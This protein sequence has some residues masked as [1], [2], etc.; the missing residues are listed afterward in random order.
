MPIDLASDALLADLSRLAQEE[1]VSAAL[2]GGAVR[3]MLL[4]REP[5][6][7]DLVI[8]GPPMPFARR[9]ARELK[10]AAVELD[11]DWGIARVV[12]SGSGKVIDL[13]KLQGDRLEDDLMRRDLAL[14]AMAVRLDGS[15]TLLDPAGGQEDIARR[16]IRAISLDNL[17][18]DPVRPLRVLRFAATLDFAIDYETLAWVEIS[19]RKLL[20]A[21][22]ERTIY[23]L[24]RILALPQVSPWVDRLYGLGIWSLLVPEF[25]ALSQIPPSLEHHL[26]GLAHSLE[27]VRQL[28]HLLSTLP[29]WAGPHAAQ[30]RAWLEAPSAHAPNL[31]AILVLGVLLHDIGKRF[32]GVLGAFGE[33]DYTGHD[34]DGV[35]TIEAIAD[36]MRLSVKERE[37]LSRMVR[38]HLEPGRVIQGGFD[39]VEIYRLF[40]ESGET[41]PGLLLL[42]LA[43]R[44]AARGPAVSDAEVERY[45]EG[46]LVLM[47][48]YWREDARFTDPPRLLNGA[49][50]KQLGL[51]PGPAY[52]R[53]LREVTEAQVR[54]E[55][56]DR[57]GAIALASKL[58]FD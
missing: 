52:S 12:L 42:A 39:P 25:D 9:L 16:R 28:D 54:G 43:D 27:S 57:D 15:K 17:L 23:E 36:R 45:H 38:L 53:I 32:R 33:P 34:R 22:P 19:R 37:H 56:T 6:D 58:A 49:D 11:A 4:G 51:P 26:N 48:S 13:A 46:I 20:D 31:R 24:M 30:A 7:L 10:G 40:Q 3:D 8:E 44:R 2:V 55:I 5:A 50:L 14:N 29:R 21:A 41:T 18:A 35:A 47:R 1:G